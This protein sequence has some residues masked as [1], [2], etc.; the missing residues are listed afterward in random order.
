MKCIQ[1]FN[2]TYVFGRKNILNKYIEFEEY[3]SNIINLIKPN[4]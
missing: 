3:S 2:K 1:K 4:E